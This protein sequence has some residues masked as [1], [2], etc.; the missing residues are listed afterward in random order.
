MQYNT[1]ISY[2][3]DI[4]KYCLRAIF[5]ENELASSP[6]ILHKAKSFYIVSPK[7][8]VAVHNGSV[9]QSTVYDVV[10]RFLAKSIAL[11]CYVYSYI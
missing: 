4:T 2:C 8:F 3:T 9:V 1:A 5:K 7:A 10:Q 6:L 11:Y